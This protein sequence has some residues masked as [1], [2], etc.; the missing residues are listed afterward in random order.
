IETVLDG[1]TGGEG[2]GY[3]PRVILS[4]EAG[5]SNE[6]PFTE[7]LR[8]VRGGDEQAAQQLVDRYAPVLQR[9]LYIRWRN[10]PLYR[11]LGVSDVLQSVFASFFLR[12]RLGEYELH[13]ADHLANLLMRMAH[14]KL[15]AQK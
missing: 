11:R 14:N 3:T 8:S 4:S 9:T 1:W 6:V 2:G 15:S 10:S 7:L 13:G 5:M 12:A